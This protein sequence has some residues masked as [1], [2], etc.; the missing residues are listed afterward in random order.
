MHNQRR[1]VGH[2]HGEVLMD[3][4]LLPGEASSQDFH[5]STRTSRGCG[6]CYGGGPLTTP[7][8]KV[9]TLN[10]LQPRALTAAAARARH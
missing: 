5:E 3:L 8:L 9:M 1:D 6:C 4:Q 2:V 10:S 7:F